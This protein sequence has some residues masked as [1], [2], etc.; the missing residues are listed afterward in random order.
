MSSNGHLPTVYR[1]LVSLPEAS[2]ERPH[3]VRTGFDFVVASLR[4]AQIPLDDLD[5]VERN[6]AKRP[7]PLSAGALAA[8]GQPLWT[9]PSPAGWPEK[10]EDW[11]S[12]TGLAQRLQWIPRV[13]SLVRDQNVYDPLA[14]RSYDCV[15]DQ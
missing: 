4:A 1:S 6:G 10:A 7:N 12:A 9:A 5:T 14:H 13:A 2:D 15:D 11:L 3:K 8:M